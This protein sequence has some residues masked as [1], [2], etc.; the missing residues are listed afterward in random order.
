MTIHLADTPQNR[1][2]AVYA[3]M[4]GDRVISLHRTERKAHEA[5]WAALQGHGGFKSAVFTIRTMTVED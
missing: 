4:F 2:G 5:A 1:A 3:L